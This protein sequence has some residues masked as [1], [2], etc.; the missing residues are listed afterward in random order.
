M[1]TRGYNIQK[2]INLCFKN[3]DSPEKP[4]CTNQ[5]SQLRY[6][7]VTLCKNTKIATAELISDDAICSTSE[8]E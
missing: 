3:L 7:T 2:A 6:S 8:S 5:N 4:E 1:T